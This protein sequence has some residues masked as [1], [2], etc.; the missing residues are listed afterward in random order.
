MVFH[1]VEEGVLSLLEA[2]IK[3]D[4]GLLVGKLPLPPSVLGRYS[5]PT[6]DFGWCI[7][8]VVRNF[9]VFVSSLASSC[10]VQFMMLKL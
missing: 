2:F 1:R 4:S 3:T 9:L 10:N 5:L 6:S 7:L 8:Y